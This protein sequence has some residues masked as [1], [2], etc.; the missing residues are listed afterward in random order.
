[1]NG[2]LYVMAAIAPPAADAAPVNPWATLLGSVLPLLAAAII[3]YVLGIL[4]DASKANADR[5]ARHQDQVLEAATG[6]LSTTM[7]M[8]KAAAKVADEREAVQHLEIDFP[9]GSV[10]R[11]ATLAEAKTN[12]V[13]TVNDLLDAIELANPHV[14]RINILAP[15]LG[16]LANNV[17]VSASNPEAADGTDNARGLQADFME[18]N[19]AFTDAVRAY[20]KVSSRRRHSR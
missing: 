10:D 17:V 6:L 8:Q 5:E 14:L 15:S 4:R 12:L 3:G 13:A 1:M 11:E 2:T 18:A 16:E 20:L 9:L 19:Q 7:K